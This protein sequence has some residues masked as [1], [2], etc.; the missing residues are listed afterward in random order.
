M[1]L[2]LNGTSG[3]TDV[4]GTAAAPAI[5]GTDTDTGVFFGT[6]TVSLSTGGTER[7]QVDSSGNLG[8]GVTPSAW[9]LTPALQVVG[10]SVLSTGNDMYLSANAY[11]G[12]S[13]WTYRASAAATQYYQL[14]GAHVWRTEIGRAHV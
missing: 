13:A 5:T 14:N 11:Y 8:L 9:T 7:L 4:N 1:A 6:N 2:I 3:I 12:S 10:A